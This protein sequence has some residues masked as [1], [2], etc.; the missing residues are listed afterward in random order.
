MA[1]LQAQGKIAEVI[2]RTQTAPARSE[3]GEV[4]DIDIEDGSLEDVPAHT[5]VMNARWG[6][7]PLPNST[8][9]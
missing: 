5:E 3:M 4:A 8:P 9:F 6:S 1:S 2:C 7:S